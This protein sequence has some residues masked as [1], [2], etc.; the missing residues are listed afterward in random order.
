MAILGGHVPADSPV[1]HFE[2]WGD[3]DSAELHRVAAVRHLAL[4]RADDD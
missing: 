2:R 1:A 3:T 4:A